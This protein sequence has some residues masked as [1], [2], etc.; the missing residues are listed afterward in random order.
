M[1]EGFKLPKHP[2]SDY[3]NPFED[4][5]AQNPFS[6][7]TNDLGPVKGVYDAP[8]VVDAPR[9][10]SEEFEV[11]LEARG[12]RVCVLGILGVLLTTC[13]LL[14]ATIA[15]VANYGAGEIWVIGFFPFSVFSLALSFPAWHMGARDLRAMMSGAMRK[16]RYRVTLWGARLGVIGISISI[17]SAAFYFTR[18]VLAIV[19]VR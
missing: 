12:G 19:T 18:L 8:S 1:N 9:E 16:D 4:D 15:E 17:L 7:G 5:R 3:Q 6:D 14:G 10:F 13:G 2:R 11:T